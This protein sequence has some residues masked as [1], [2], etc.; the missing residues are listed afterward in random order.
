MLILGVPGLSKL[1]VDDDQGSWILRQ[2]H[3]N[4]PRMIAPVIIADGL[5]GLGAVSAIQ[6]LHWLALWPATGPADSP[7]EG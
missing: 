5:E 6:P 1:P 2:S 7:G 4:M 3:A